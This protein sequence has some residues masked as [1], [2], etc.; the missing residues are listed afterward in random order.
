MS[1]PSLF[2]V[3]SRARHARRRFWSRVLGPGL[4]MAVVGASAFAYWS[5][6]GTGNGSGST[7]TSVAVTLSPGVAAADLR[8]GGEGNVVL[9]V[10]NPNPYVAEIGSLALDVTRGD[11]GFAVDAAHLDCAFTALDYTTQTNG[12]AGWTVPQASGGDDG[13]LS[14]TLSDALA[15]SDDAANACQGAT[16]TVYLMV[17][18]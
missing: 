18:P 3:R 10:T 17:G 6:E 7:A 16:L 2:A 14:V 5:A 4:L 13:T 8:P 15:M 9:Q 1:M 11:G 12:G